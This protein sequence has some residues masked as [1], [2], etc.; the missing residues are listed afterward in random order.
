[1]SHKEALIILHQSEA[2]LD[3]N[4]KLYRSIGRTQPPDILTETTK[5]QLD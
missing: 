4:E 2:I 1:M 5:A 3:H